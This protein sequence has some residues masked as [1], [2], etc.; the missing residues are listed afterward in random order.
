MM[1]GSRELDFNL[2]KKPFFLMQTTSKGN[3][4]GLKAVKTG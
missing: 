4:N 2:G 1:I 3:K